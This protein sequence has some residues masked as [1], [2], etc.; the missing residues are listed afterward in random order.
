M[1]A[2]L[3]KNWKMRLHNLWQLTKEGKFLFQIPGVLRKYILDEKTSG[4]NLKEK[5]GVEP[6]MSDTCQTLASLSDSSH[7]GKET[8][9]QIKPEWC[10][11]T[12]ES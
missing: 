3:V 1:P 8:P 10:P 11:H 4:G 2:A 12:G 6:L 7:N 9:K 5:S